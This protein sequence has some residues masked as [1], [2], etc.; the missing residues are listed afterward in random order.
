MVTK[1]TNCSTH[2]L[3]GLCCPLSSQ[4]MNAQ[5]SRRAPPQ[6]DSVTHHAQRV[7]LQGVD[8][9]QAAYTVVHICWFFAG[10]L[11]SLH[12]PLI[13][14]ISSTACLVAHMI[15]PSLPNPT[16]LPLLPCYLTPPLSPSLVRF[17]KIKSRVTK[18]TRSTP[19]HS[20]L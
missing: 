16:V 9:H 3:P 19:S 20:L 1:V 10:S 4:Q 8:R 7:C 12:S 6:I 5:H 13:R 18:V 2:Y 11:G 14:L 17:C 15:A